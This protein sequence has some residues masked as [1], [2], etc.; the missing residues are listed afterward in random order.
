MDLSVTIA[1]ESDAL[2]IAALRTTVVAEHLTLQYGRGHWSSCATEKGAACDI[3]TTRVLVA[4][5]GNGIIAT[6]SLAT[7]KPWAI[8]L[9]YFASVPRALYLRNMA[10]A[11]GV[12][13]RGT[14]RHLLEA[15]KS[16]ARARPANAIR[17]DAYD[18]D[19]GAGGHQLAV[20]RL[21]QAC[22]FGLD[23]T[24]QLIH[25]FG[26]GV[27]ASRRWQSL[28]REKRAEV[29]E[30]MDRLRTMR[31]LIDRV[32]LCRCTDL[33]ECG[34]IASAVTDSK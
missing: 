1:T 18:A 26:S 12:Q 33:S 19:A 27:P 16:A 34:R 14:G 5:G 21:A 4:R 17:L 15:G 6:L 23:A 7:K 10:V 32:L 25:G 24:R 2:E 30:Q 20:V 31:Q 29:D 11:P 3:K 22:G 8:D 28:A 13:R 9:K